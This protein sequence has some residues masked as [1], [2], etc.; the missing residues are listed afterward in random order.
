MKVLMVSKALV[1]GAYQ[2]KIEEIA[3][4][5]GIEVVLVVPPSWR[6]PS[7]ER[8]LE[9]AHTDGYRLVVSPV[10]F[11]GHF[12]LFF[13]PR[14]GRLLDE[15]RPDI[16]HIDEEPYNLATFLAVREA[17]QR[18]IPALFFTW[19]NLCR[20][21]PWP[22]AWME[23]YVH[24]AAAWAIA[25]TETAARVLERKGYGGPV[26]VIPQFGVDPETFAPPGPMPSTVS[27]PPA[28]RPFT[29]GFAGRLA[30]EKGLALLVDACARLSMEY[31][32]VVL[33][34]GPQLNEIRNRIRRHGIEARV[35][36]DGAVSSAEMPRRLETMD[37]LVLPSVTRPSWAEQFGRVLVEAMACGVAVVG[38][39]CGEIPTVVSDGGLI[40]P[41]GDA[42]A[43]AS[44]L[45]LLARE[46]LMRAE[47]AARG[48]RRVLDRFTHQRIAADTTEVYRQMAQKRLPL[49]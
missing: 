34:N 47:L 10:A 48:R 33:G 3:R 20:R 18:G 40:F 38:S 37:V 31:R 45:D 30:P 15:H 23:R 35:R 11:N 16:V 21:Y 13:F 9:R 44:A 19:Q 24:R 26:S 39:T 29:I 41:E 12:H 6:D 17:Q 8:P 36:F 22:F 42:S 14:L 32:L 1:V 49:H 5:P 43:L 2:R 7:Y 4:C 27:P 46:P 28:D 25:G